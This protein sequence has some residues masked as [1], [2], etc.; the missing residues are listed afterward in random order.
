MI[1]RRRKFIFL[2]LLLILL[3]TIVVAPVKASEV[4][5][6]GEI[7]QGRFLVPMRGIFENLGASVD[8][9]G[10]TRTVTGI[11]GDI[12]VI[13][14][15]DQK[16]AY[17][18]GKLVELDVPATIINGSTFVPTRFVSES[19]G[20]NVLW[21]GEN[22]KATITLDGKV[23]NV[24]EEKQQ[25]NSSPS[26][27]V[28][29]QI[30]LEVNPKILPPGGGQKA[31]ITITVTDKNGNPIQGANVHLNGESFEIGNRSAQLSATEL[32]TDESGRATATYTTLAVDDNKQIGVDVTVIADGLWS[33]KRLDFV[34]SNR[35][36]KVEG[37]VVNPFTA[38]PQ[39]GVMLYYWNKDLN[40]G[41]GK[42]YTDANGRYSSMLPTGNYDIWFDIDIS[43]IAHN[44]QKEYT[45]SSGYTINNKSMQDNLPINI[46]ESGA[47]YTVNYNKGIFRGVISNAKAGQELAI[48]LSSTTLA[49]LT[50]D[51]SFIVPLM[52][53]SYDVYIK[54][55]GNPF[56]RGVS[57]KSGQ[58]LNLG[59]IKK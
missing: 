27:T 22:R 8:W 19:L 38:T 30:S 48:I 52:P 6:Q 4:S 39:A 55:E 57:I 31:V 16:I 14:T 35:A 33:N 3:L 56:L 9:D 50:N 54:G 58:V 32:T 42:S 37:V 45:G 40:K 18:N 11:K 43:G 26:P 5:L 41:F 49:K 46:R 23:I 10:Q 12:S 7:V 47:N 2:L 28:S 44:I 36:S 29:E 17:V 34:A 15:I 21:D 53:G 1:N 51:G 24:H 25:A 20:A 59:V 13:L